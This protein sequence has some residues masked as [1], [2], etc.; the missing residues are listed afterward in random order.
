MIDYIDYFTSINHSV[1]LKW[2]LYYEKSNYTMTGSTIGKIFY[3]NL[4]NI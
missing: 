3:K 1:N 4:T 2:V